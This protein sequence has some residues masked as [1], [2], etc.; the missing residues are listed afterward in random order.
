M[1]KASKAQA[2]VSAALVA[3]FVRMCSACACLFPTFVGWCCVSHAGFLFHRDIAD[4]FSP[5]EMPRYSARSQ[6]Q[7]CGARSKDL[8]YTIWEGTVSMH[9]FVTENV[10][11][12]K[13]GKRTDS[14]PNAELTNMA[15]NDTMSLSKFDPRRIC[16]CPA[17]VCCLRLSHAGFLFHNDFADFSTHWRCYDAERAASGDGVEPGRK[18]LSVLPEATVLMHRTV[19]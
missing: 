1:S 6:R 8:P 14:V 18:P 19:N 3:H 12:R 13:T 15:S 7:R 11:S 17:L 5:T 10:S 2:C 9:K 4:T 16:M